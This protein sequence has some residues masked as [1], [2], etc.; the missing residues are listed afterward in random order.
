LITTTCDDLSDREVVTSRHVR[1]F[2]SPD[3]LIE[4]G[5]VRSEIIVF[6]GLTVS[7]DTQQPGWRWSTHVKPIVKTDSCQA[8]HIGVVLRGTLHVVLDDGTQFEA[9]PL[10]LMDIPPGH[11]AWVVGHVPVETL[12]WGG[13]KT[14]LAPLS[15]LGERIV[16]TLLLTDIV[17]STGTARRVGDRSW[18]DL[19]GE[20]QFRTREVVGE[21]R[22]RVVDFAG[23]GVL[24]MFD[25]AARA[26][27]CATALHHTAEDLG[28][29]IR[30]AVHTGEVEIAEESIHGVAIH[31]ASRIL[32]LANPQEILTSDTTASL[33]RDS[34]AVF[35]DRGEHRLRG[36]PD[37]RHIYGVRFET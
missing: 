31:E 30:S 20:Y 26:I 24:A 35:E 37:S 36:L 34:G 33:A 11:D 16:T 27:R 15:T 29:S 8:R 19:L 10:D 28:L 25:G 22:G 12:A 3:E 14:W 6:G 2:S 13:G 21:Y 1:S 7:H 9:G 23:D 18:S 5:P 4:F 32:A 17:D